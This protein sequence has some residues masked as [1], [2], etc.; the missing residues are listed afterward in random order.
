MIITIFT[1]KQL[2]M[3]SAFLSPENL[4]I[5]PKTNEKIDN[6]MDMIIRPKPR[7]VGLKSLM[8]K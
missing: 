2:P 3:I 1:K 8:W 7:A 5:K 6:Q 4:N